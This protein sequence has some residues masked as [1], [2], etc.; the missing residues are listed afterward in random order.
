LVEIGNLKK[1]NTFVPNQD[2][3]KRFLNK[4]LC[5]ITT[6]DSICQFSYNHI[7]NKAQTV[8]VTWFNLRQ[9]PASFF[10]VEHSTDIHNSLLKFVELQDFY[11]D[12]FI[13]ADQHRYR[14]FKATG[15]LYRYRIAQV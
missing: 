13:V 7:I 9:M 8:D 11:T 5:E 10:E 14:E 15:F 2:R 1:L 4:R 6:L 3:N 12:F